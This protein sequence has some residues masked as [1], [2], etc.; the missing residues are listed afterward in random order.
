MKKALLIV[1]LLATVSA[2]SAEARPPCCAFAQESARELSPEERK[3]LE[4]FVAKFSDE[5]TG[6]M[7]PGIMWTL[8]HASYDQKA[9]KE[10]LEYLRTFL[11]AVGKKDEAALARLGGARGFKEKFVG[12]LGHADDTVQGSA[13][14]ML[15]MTGDSKVAPHIAKLLRDPRPPRKSDEDDYPRAR[16]AGGRAAIA[17]GLLGAAEYK[18]DLVKLLRSANEHDITGAAQGLSFLKAADAAKDIARL[19]VEDNERVQ[20]A[21]IDALVDLGVAGSYTKE[22]AKG[23]STGFSSEVRAASVFALVKLKAREYSKDIAALLKERFSKQEA[24]IALALMGANEHA[25]EIASLLEDEEPLN[26]CAAMLAL[27][28]LGAEKYAP[29]IH[30]RMLAEKS[31]VEDY[32]ADALVLLESREFAGAA[33]AL[34]LEERPGRMTDRTPDIRV[35]LHFVPA[36]MEEEMKAL[37][38]RFAKSFELMKAVAA[39]GAKKGGAKP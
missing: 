18:P 26:R 22:I 2:T 9:V 3:G 19:L 5:K 27:G 14:L 16:Y 20:V 30:R 29:A 12:Y 35:S 24:A 28:I 11:T 25:G 21:A 4:E 31:Y 8:T 38:V 23:L 33:M 36:F 15:A 6:Q 17:L 7:M 13:A 32:G 39:E 37:Q 1:L 34:I 10:I